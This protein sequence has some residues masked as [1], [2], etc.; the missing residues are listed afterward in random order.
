MDKGN[1]MEELYRI[2]ESKIQNYITTEFISII[3]NKIIS[4]TDAINNELTDKQQA[5]L[6]DILKLEHEKLLLVE[7]EVL[8][9]AFTLGIKLCR[10]LDCLTHEI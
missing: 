5:L 1:V 8:I 3:G 4:K 6:Q 2:C 7:Q 9:Y 10:K